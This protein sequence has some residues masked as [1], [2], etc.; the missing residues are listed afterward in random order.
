MLKKQYR[1]PA[2]TRL[3][4]P[5]SI[6]STLFSLKVERTDLPYNR[7]AFVVRKSIDKRASQRNRMKRRFRSSVEEMI[8][9]IRPG[10]DMLFFLEKGIIE[11]H[12]QELCS[13]IR[14]ALQEKKLL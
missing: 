14:S 13:E 11:K 12:R 9:E 3:L 6:H 2:H 10:H 1:L 7:F 8:Q 4:S 5:L